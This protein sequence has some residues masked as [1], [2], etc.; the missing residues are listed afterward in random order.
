TAIHFHYAGFAAPILTGMAGRALGRARPSHWRAYLWI[1]VGVIVGPP[2]VAVG[3]TFSRA[4]ELVAVV[5]LATSLIGLSVLTFF[6][7]VPTARNLI[8]R[9]FLVLSSVSLVLGMLFA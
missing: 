6:D 7:I 1:A 3:I 4:I 9:T 8:A 2:L 5:V